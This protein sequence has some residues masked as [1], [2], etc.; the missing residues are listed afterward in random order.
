VGKQTSIEINGK[1]YDALTGKLISNSSVQTAQSTPVTYTSNTGI[2]DGFKRPRK[3]NVARQTAKH[4]SKTAQR[5]KTL[6]RSSVKKPKTVA[7]PAEKLAQ[8]SLRKKLG[9]PHS[10]V[11]NAKHSERSPSISKFQAQSAKSSVL[12]KTTNHPVKPAPMKQG[13]VASVGRP[14][15]VV[16]APPVAKTHAKP[17]P[18]HRSKA[19]E[20]LIEAALTNAHSHTE[21]T[22][23]VPKKRSKLIGKL[24]ISSKSAAMSSA[25]LA[26]VLLG[27]FFA[28]QNVPN[29]AMRVAATR[30][31]F[32]AT[33]PGYQPSGFSFKGP[34]NYNSGQVTVSFRSNTDT[35]EYDLTQRSS[36]WNSDALLA[37]YI[38]DE[39]K[40][41]QTYT[42]RGRTLYIYD[43]SNATWVDN[44]IWYQ[45]EGQSNMTTDQLIRIAA[46]I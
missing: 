15:P 31:G 16:S 13:I 39:N 46:S 4:A 37:N 29:L 7:S 5:S 36:N 41:Y 24:G 40:Q 11:Q 27:G 8:Q 2:V 34:I 1:K 38:I 10:R 28:I 25:V 19:T 35:R 22:H 12:K 18:T 17:Q 26:G 33:M 45:V 21:P 6:V 43:G 32:D 3:S 42:D 20:K 44:G 30:A 23:K 9:T 14:A